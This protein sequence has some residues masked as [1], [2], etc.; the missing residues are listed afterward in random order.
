MT[1]TAKSNEG[2][3]TEMAVRLSD[4]ALSGI[5]SFEDALALLAETYGQESVVVASDVLGDGFAL[6]DSKDKGKLVGEAFVIVNWSFH[7]GENG[8][9]VV[10]RIVTQSNKKLILT[11][12]SQG[13]CKQLSTYSANTGKYAAMVVGKGLRQ[14][15]YTF[16]DLE[17]KEK[18]ATTFYLDVSAV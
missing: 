14:S 11:D 3:T 4:D 15:D 2:A 10:A 18:S 12:G 9:F 13:I 6:L 7:I 8:E 16:T 17:G 1:R 5:S